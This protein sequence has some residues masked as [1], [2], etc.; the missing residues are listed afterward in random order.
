MNMKTT[1]GRWVLVSFV[2]LF[3][4]AG[5]E[6]LPRKGLADPRGALLPAFTVYSQD[7]PE[8]TLP[9]GF[10][11]GG[12]L[13]IIY[14]ESARAD[15]REW[16][17]AI[18][19]NP[20]SKPAVVVETNPELDVDVAWN[21]NELPGSAKLEE[22]MPLIEITGAERPDLARVILFNESGR[23]LWIWDGG[24]HDLKLS[25]LRAAAR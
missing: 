24:Y 23:I 21:K 10:R 25:E 6:S 15:A 5:C 4:F 17:D 7:N 20:L 9:D 14:K 18:L 16:L 22:V 2:C 1:L 8:V 12:V 11:D 13:V 3:G 19:A